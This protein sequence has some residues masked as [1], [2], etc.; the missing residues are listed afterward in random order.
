MA[1]G[2]APLVVDV[3]IE[4]EVGCDRA[5]AC[6]E[7]MLDDSVGTMVVKGTSMSYGGKMSYVVAT[8]CGTGKLRARGAD[9][10]CTDVVCKE[11]VA[12]DMDSA[13]YEGDATLTDGGMGEATSG[14][15]V[16]ECFGIIG[17]SVIA[18]G[19]VDDACCSGACVNVDNLVDV[20]SLSESG[21]EGTG[22]MCIEYTPSG[23]CKLTT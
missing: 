5:S 19:R 21:V 23:V 18:S 22:S 6:R 11:A 8:V 9:V 12:V 14:V 13:S 4:K 10:S 2:T 20:C 1:G 7:I 15:A 17:D 16:S 3:A